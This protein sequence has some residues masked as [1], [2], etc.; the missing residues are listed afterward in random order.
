M[1]EE[2]EID[3]HFKDRYSMPLHDRT[4]S[5]ILCSETPIKLLNTISYRSDTV[6]RLVGFSVLS[7]ARVLT[8]YAY[9]RR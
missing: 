2:S 5:T 8:I 7:P 6:D 3:F 4:Y 1:G 9:D